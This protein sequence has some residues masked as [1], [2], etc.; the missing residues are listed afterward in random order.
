MRHKGFAIVLTNV[1]IGNVAG[2]AAQVASEL[3]AE[4]VLDDAMS[5]AQQTVAMVHGGV[6]KPLHQV[7]GVAAGLRTAIMFLT[8]GRPNP[9]D[10]HLHADEEMFIRAPTLPRPVAGV[11]VPI[12]FSAPRW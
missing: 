5:R 3:T 2:L 6:L 10:A 1:S 4:V 11:S 9:E 8:R 7:Q 12:P